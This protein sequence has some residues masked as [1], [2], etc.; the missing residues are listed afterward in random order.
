MSP[1][2]FG[3][4]PYH[5]QHGAALRLIIIGTDH[6]VQRSDPQL[7]AFIEQTVDEEHVN[8]IGEERPFEATSVAREVAK[9]RQIPWVQVDMTTEHR[10]RAGI[11][12]KLDTRMLHWNSNEYG[13]PVETLCYAPR[14][15]GIREHFWLDRIA[16]RNVVGPAMI[17]C[18]AAHAR[19]LAEKAESRG[20]STIL[21]FFPEL[22][23]SQFWIS[24]PPKLF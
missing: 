11:K 22:P 21:H 24:I 4:K 6:D 23:G 19:P 16:E 17:V 15:D 5:D 3:H 18:G 14:E 12:D 1:F 20:V 7:K 13:I 9:S 2:R 10:I 8:I